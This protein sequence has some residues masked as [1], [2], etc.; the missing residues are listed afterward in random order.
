MTP[1]P[2]PGVGAGS[3]VRLFIEQQSFRL[4]DPFRI[5]RGVRTVADVVA[6]RIDDG[7]H[8]GTGE[9][10]PYARYGESIAGTISEIESI[11]QEIEAGASRADLAMLLGAGAA[12]N[13]LDAA[14]WA[15]EARRAGRTVADMVGVPLPRQ[16][17]TAMTI[18]LDEPSMMAEKAR[19]WP[20]VRTLKVKVSA[21][22]PLECV[23]AVRSVAPHARLIVDPNESWT[24]DHCADYMADLAAMR[25]DMLEQPV[26][27]D[28]G[29]GLRRMKRLVPVCADEAFHTSSDLAGLVGAYD[30]I[31]IKLDKTGGLTEALNV[32]SLAREHHVK[33][34]IGCMLG[35]SLGVAPA[36]V[37]TGFADFVD[38]DCPLLLA[39]DRSDGL[40][41]APGLLST[42]N[43][44]LW[45]S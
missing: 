45:P 27:A 6:V 18:T 2:A 38:L 28:Q 36:I 15:L 12:R 13:A 20:S 9:C 41:L 37:L 34:M 44:H 23:A 29:E 40:G 14:L 22:Q 25:V 3:R 10:T 5:S 35:S 43:A 39:K 32:I 19:Q 7:Q 11:R 16:V 31:N 8:C 17:K 26:P 30:Y 21:H 24:C 1:P 42:S 4:R 33:I